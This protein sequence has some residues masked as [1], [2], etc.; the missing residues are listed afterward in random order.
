LVLEL[1]AVNGPG[2]NGFLVAS[3]VDL[4]AVEAAPLI[5]QAFAATCVD[6]VV[7]GDWDAVQIALGL[8]SAEEVESTAPQ[9][10]SKIKH[11]TG[12]KNTK[13]K[14]V[15]QSRKKNRKR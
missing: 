14:V 7:I 8:K 3:L 10:P 13:S 12:R 11:E 9:I 2:A 1:F 15:K 5:E 6:L 4:H